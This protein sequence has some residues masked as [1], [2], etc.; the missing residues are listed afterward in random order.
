MRVVWR[1]TSICEVRQS[2]IEE[3]SED[4][5]LYAL[6][7]DEKQGSKIGWRDQASMVKVNKRFNVFVS[8]RSLTSYSN[9]A[10][11]LQWFTFDSDSLEVFEGAWDILREYQRGIV[12]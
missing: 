10:D 4:T 3:E 12:E 11:R 2:Q 8:I 6:L 5:S 9:E 1:Y 7:Q